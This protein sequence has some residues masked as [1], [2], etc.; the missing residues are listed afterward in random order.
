MNQLVQSAARILS[1]SNYAVALTGAGISTPSGIPDFRSPSYGLWQ[2]VDPFEVASRWGFERHPEKFYAW[3]K[4]L[5]AAMVAARPNDAHRALAV[6]ES[7]SLIRAVI[8]QNVDGL[9]QQAGSRNV[10]EVHG[11]LRE[12]TCLACGA[13]YPSEGLLERFVSDGRLPRCTCGGVLKPSVVL[14]GE[15]LPPDVAQAAQEAVARCDAMLVA[16]SSLTVS[17]AGDWPAEMVARGG[18]LLIVNQTPTPLDDA[19][20]VVI[21]G[22]VG[23]VLPAVARAAGVKTRTLRNRVR[24][25]IERTVDQ[26]LPRVLG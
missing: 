26:L 9:H 10:H 7:A 22:D 11:H 2:H 17:P 4:P 18:D 13:T 8:T 24:R 12:A 5:A 20:T 23:Q 14:F 16:G 1:G 25:R 19:A 21:R 15:L 3:V 6:L